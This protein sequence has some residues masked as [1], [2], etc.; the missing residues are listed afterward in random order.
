MAT[1]L[2]TGYANTTTN[3]TTNVYTCSASKAA[4]VT[5]AWDIA[6]PSGCHVTIKAGNLTIWDDTSAGTE[7]A[8]TYRT[9]TNITQ[10]SNFSTTDIK[11]NGVGRIAPLDDTYML[12]ANETVSYIIAS[13]S[14]TSVSFSVFAVEDDVS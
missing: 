1:I 4:R 10:A 3:G 2:E 5:M 12:S 9:G 8:Q 11:A 13:A 14:A 6:G 7:F